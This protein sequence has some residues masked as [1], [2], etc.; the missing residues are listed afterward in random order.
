[1]VGYAAHNLCGATNNHGP[2]PLTH[3]TQL[4]LTAH[5]AINPIF[6]VFAKNSA[7]WNFRQTL[8]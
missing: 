7:A 6:S 5:T 8:V 2:A 1:M 3:P 4:P